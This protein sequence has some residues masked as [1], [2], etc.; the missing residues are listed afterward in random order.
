MARAHLP[1]PAVLLPPLMA[2]VHKLLGDEAM[3]A[4]VE[5]HGG[6]R[7]PVPG[8]MLERH[9][10]A[11]LLGFEPARRLVEAFGPGTLTVGLCKTW[12]VHV[13]R[14]QGYSYDLIARRLGMTSYAVFRIIKQG[15]TKRETRAEVRQL[16]LAI[17]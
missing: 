17:D 10:L 15:D 4:L 14:G 5:M 11:R 2:E 16:S 7:L 9:P 1:D 3:L 6:T 8:K 12:R 13:L